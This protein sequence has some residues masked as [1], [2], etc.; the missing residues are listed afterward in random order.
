MWETETYSSLRPGVLRVCHQ[1]L[2]S[3]PGQIVHLAKY[4]LCKH[5]DLSLDPQYLCKKLGVVVNTANLS[6]SEA[7]IEGSWGLLPATL[8]ELENSRY[9]ERPWLKKT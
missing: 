5:S 9:S 7:E 1:I 6:G 2:S 8:A 3:G 4:L